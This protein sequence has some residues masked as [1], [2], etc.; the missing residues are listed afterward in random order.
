MADNGNSGTTRRIDRET[1]NGGAY[2]VVFF[3]D[4][5]GEPVPESQATKAEIVE[6]TSTDEVVMRTYAEVVS[7]N[8]R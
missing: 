3:Q 6:Y 4:D 5:N 8:G 7:G 2:A 1:P